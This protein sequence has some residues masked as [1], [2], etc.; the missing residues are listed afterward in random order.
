MVF[1]FDVS[2]QARSHKKCH[3]GFILERG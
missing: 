3:I 1:I 2:A